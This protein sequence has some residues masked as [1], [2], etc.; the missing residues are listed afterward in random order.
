MKK[1]VSKLF[2]F[3]LVVLVMVVSLTACGGKKMADGGMAMENVAGGT[4]NYGKGTEISD[5]V[6]TADKTTNVRDDRKIIENIELSIETKEFDTLLEN[7]NSQIDTLNGYVESSDVYGREFGSYENRS[8]NMTI[9]IPAD[10]SHTF[11]DYISKNSVVVSRSVTTEDVTLTYVDIESRVAALTAEKE[12]LE[13]L[14]K[15]A[16][17][18][19]EIVTVRDKLT[20]VI[21]EIESY[22]SQL[23]TY[24]NLVDYCTVTLRIEEVERTTVVEEQNIWQEIGTNLKNNFA[25]VWDGTIALFVLAVSAIPYLIPFIII[26]MIIVIPITARRRKKRKNQEKKDDEQ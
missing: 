17:T 18:V 24:D 13:A 11:S 10:K 9:R 25:D 14:L 16:K 1:K 8:A 4:E 21:Y 5:T 22:E 15:N 3:I 26:G 19:E 12:S 7:L 23:R 2:A 6:S 20:E